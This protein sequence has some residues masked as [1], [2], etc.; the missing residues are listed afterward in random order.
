MNKE[1]KSEDI[2]QCEYLIEKI[3]EADKKLKQLKV[4]RAQEQKDHEKYMKDMN[5]KLEGLKLQRF[6]LELSIRKYELL[7]IGAGF[8]FTAIFIAIISGVI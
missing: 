3:A 5:L 4:E 7:F 2:K 6:E 1:N 8:I